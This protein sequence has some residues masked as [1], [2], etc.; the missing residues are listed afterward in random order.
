M[1][2]IIPLLH[3]SRI[4]GVVPF[5]SVEN[6]NISVTK[7]TL[8]LSLL[9]QSLVEICYLIYC[10]QRYVHNYSSSG[11]D[12]R[13]TVASASAIVNILFDHLNVCSLIYVSQKLPTLLNVLLKNFSF[14]DEH[15]VEINWRWS[16]FRV[17]LITVQTAM[18]IVVK[19]GLLLYHYDHLKLSFNIGAR[20]IYGMILVLEQL[21]SILCLEL[22]DRFKLINQ[23]IR[24]LK[25][26]TNLEDLRLIHDLYKALFKNHCLVAQSFGYFLFF[27]LSQMLMLML[28]G[29]LTIFLV[30]LPRQNSEEDK[31]ALFVSVIFTLDCLRRFCFITRNCGRLQLE[32][33]LI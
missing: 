16:K 18:F 9:V 32:V 23:K 3:L 24:H 1:F 31:L 5:S 28:Y 8:R 4:F 19:N 27:D 29:F 14:L 21:I 13:L 25:G 22:L 6:Y 30:N 15:L 12:V 26:N 7:W 17:Y 2:N 11:D 20:F 10:Y 33:R